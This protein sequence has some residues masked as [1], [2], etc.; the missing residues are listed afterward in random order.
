[1]DKIKQIDNLQSSIESWLTNID[2]LGVYDLD[3]VLSSVL[4]KENIFVLMA[5]LS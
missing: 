4:V 5:L 1:M 2:S 3:R